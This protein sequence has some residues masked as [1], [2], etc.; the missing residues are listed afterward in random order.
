[1]KF[2]STN[3]SKHQVSLADAV[4][5]G[6][7]PDGGLYMPMEIPI[8]PDSFFTDCKTYSLVE[9]GVKVISTLLA[10]DLKVSQ[11]E[12]IISETLS[13]EV[14]STRL[15]DEISVLELFH[16]PTLAFKDFGARFC[17]R[18]LFEILGNHVRKIKVLVATSGD[19]GSAV[20]N[21]FYKIPGIEVVIL[22]PKGKVSPLQEKQFATLG[23]NITALEVEGTFDDCQRLVKEAFL[24]RELNQAMTL[25][26]ANS[27]NIARW[28]PQAL[29]YFYSW[30]R[31]EDSKSKVVYSVPSGNF[32]NLAAGVLAYR[33]GLP[34]DKFIAATNINKIVPDYLDGGDFVP[35]PSQQTISNSMDVGNASN[36][37]RLKALYN[38]NDEALRKHITGYYYSDEET[39]DTMRREYQDSSYI[40]DPHT[41]VAYR[42]MQE[43]LQMQGPAKTKYKGIVL[44]TAH[45]AKFKS[46]VDDILEMNFSLPE[47]LKKYLNATIE[48]TKISTSFVEFKNYLLDYLHD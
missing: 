39:A 34:V 21:G 2:Y 38:N 4:L 33:M 17:S 24:D 37:P 19:T 23:E 7:A 12:K 35:R 44:G 18:L 27:I 3:D 20:A 25:T 14:P 28:I 1:M 30:S 26:S 32:G 5:R 36:F 40:L 16:G 31:L 22:Y 46:T 13:F 42:A 6:L 10:D 48:K 11:I 8:L 9:I 15:T 43:F 45:P 47:Q 41:A 29:Y